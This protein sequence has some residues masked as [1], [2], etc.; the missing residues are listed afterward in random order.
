MQHA[1]IL[2]LAGLRID[3]RRCG[4]VRKVNHRV[5]VASADGS[6][7]FEQASRLSTNLDR[8]CMHMTGSCLPNL[9]D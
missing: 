8:T 2:A 6:C 3:G 1:D 9:S 5:A 7:Y 4:D